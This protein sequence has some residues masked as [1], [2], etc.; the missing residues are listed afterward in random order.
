MKRKVLFLSLVF[1]AVLT[2]YTAYAFIVTRGLKVYLISTRLGKA[3]VSSW[4]IT[5]LM[6]LIF[7]IPVL[8]SLIKKVSSKILFS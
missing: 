4:Q 6:A 1:A 2:V 5:L 8:V 7:W 3:L